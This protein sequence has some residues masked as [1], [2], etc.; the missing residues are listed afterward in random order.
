MPARTQAPDEAL[1]HSTQW[2]GRVDLAYMAELLQADANAVARDLEDRG[3]IYRNPE[4]GDHETAAAY[5]SGNVKRKLHAALAGQ[6]PHPG[7]LPEFQ[8]PQEL[9]PHHKP[10]PDME[11][12]E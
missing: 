4:T 8:V 5:L 7:E 9:D 3:L 11:I 12:F 2:R 1:A 6:A 10:K